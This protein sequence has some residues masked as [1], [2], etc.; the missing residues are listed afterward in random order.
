M[1]PATTDTANKR[2]QDKVVLITG[3]AGGI[4][5]ALA[6]QFAAEGA[7]LAVA[8]INSSKITQTCI[9]MEIY[10]I[11]PMLIYCRN[12]SLMRWASWTSSLI[13]LASS[14]EGQ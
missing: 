9:L 2:F 7:R 5:T 13:M 1:S 14:P 3:A 10:E 11:I 12:R 6:R 4:G 8:D